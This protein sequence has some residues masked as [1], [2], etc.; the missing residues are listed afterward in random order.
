MVKALVLNALG[1]VS[2]PLYLTPEFFAQKP[3]EVLLGPG[4]T[5]EMLNDDSIGRALDALF[6]AGLTEVFARWP[7]MPC[8]VSASNVGSCTWTFRPFTCTGPTRGM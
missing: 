4:I 8:A 1:F 3:V 6:K 5:A 2:R 7:P